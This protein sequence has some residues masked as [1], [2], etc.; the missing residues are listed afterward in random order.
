MDGLPPVGAVVR[1]DERAGPDYR[2]GPVRFW[3]TGACW[4]YPGQRMV[5]LL[6]GW[7][8]EDGHIGPGPVRVYLAG[9]EVIEDP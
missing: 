2:D 4:A 9:V 1:L 5:A 3:V 8:I 6:A 7:R